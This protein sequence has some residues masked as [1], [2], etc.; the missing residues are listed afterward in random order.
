MSLYHALCRRVDGMLAPTP[1]RMM[2]V[3]PVIPLLATPLIGAWWWIPSLIFAV[4]WLI[5]L[6]WRASVI[7]KTG[8]IG[9][10]AAD[11]ERIGGTGTAPRPVPPPPGPEA[12]AGMDPLQRAVLAL[13]QP[14]DV[15]LS[16][17]PDFVCKGDELALDFE[18]AL[19]ASPDAARTDAQ[20]AALGALDGLI[21]SMSGER[22][23]DFWLDEG[24]LRSHPIWEEIRASA[25]ACAAAFGWEMRIPPPSGA[26]YIPAGAWNG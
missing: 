16:L 2:A 10:D 14:A 25:R 6:L 13:A 26:T 23:S 18:D 8:L 17:F 3:I 11:L 12:S 7:A 9:A 20:R 24:M 1:S 4:A 21:T 15:Q 19:L 22:N 5:F